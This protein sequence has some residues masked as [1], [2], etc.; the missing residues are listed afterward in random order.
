MVA[1]GFCLIVLFVFSCVCVCGGALFF[2]GG[3]RV[4][5][6]LKH[7]FIL[8]FFGG[9]VSVFGGFVG[10]LQVCLEVFVWPL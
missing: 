5:G 1:Y 3:L 4:G 9:G 7:F 6:D 2:F 10:F 8:F